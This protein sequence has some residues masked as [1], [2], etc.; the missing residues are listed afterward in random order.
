MVTKLFTYQITIV[1]GVETYHVSTSFTTSFNTT[2]ST[3]TTLSN[4][5][6]NN[7]YRLIQVGRPPLLLIRLLALPILR[8][9]TQ[10]QHLVR[11]STPQTRLVKIQLLATLQLYLNA[12]PLQGQKQKFRL[13]GRIT[14]DTG[15]VHNGQRVKRSNR[16]AI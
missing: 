2:R 1:L 11:L 10:L 5:R 7:H 3:T 13:Q 6:F 4:Q 15:M 14:S 16:L 8:L 9:Q 12:S